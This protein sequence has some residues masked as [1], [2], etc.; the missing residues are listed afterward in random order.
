[1]NGKDSGSALGRTKMHAEANGSTGKE[2]ARWSEPLIAD[3]IYR[4]YEGFLGGPTEA[5]EALGHQHCQLWRKLLDN[6]PGIARYLRRDLLRAA[7]AQ[8]LALETIDAIDIGV[9]DQLM[10]VVMRRRLRSRD[11]ARSDGMTLVHAASTLGEIR[12]AA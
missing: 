2:I 4:A 10:D 11:A 1:M 6:E 7:A 8:G 5:S 9:F 3:F 12:K